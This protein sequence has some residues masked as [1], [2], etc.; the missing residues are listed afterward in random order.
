MPIGGGLEDE[1]RIVYDRFI[2]L[3]TRAAAPG[4]QVHVLV[5]TAASFDEPAAAKSK[6]ESLARYAPGVKVSVISRPTPQAETV[7]LIDA[8]SAIF[9]TGGD[10]KRITTRYRPD[11]ADSTP[12]RDAMLRLLTRG[13]VI[14]GTSAGD[15]MMGDVM[16]LTGRSAEALG[17]TTTRTKPGADDDADDKADPKPLGPQIGRGMGFLSAAMTDSHFLERHRFGRLVA[18]LEASGQ[19]LGVGVSENAAVEID[20]AT[21]EMVGLSEAESLLVDVGGLTRDG[22]TRRGIR[23]KL[24]TRG[25][26]FNL[27]TGTVPPAQ[28]PAG[29]EFMRMKDDDTGM[30]ARQFFMGAAAQP[31]HLTLDGYIQKAWKIGDGWVVVDIETAKPE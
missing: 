4:G 5:A 14:A 21:G 16:F 1:N 17:I 26:K 31:R 18:A 8:A 19:R 2:E 15:A 9:F 24:V 23:A 13:G 11:G 29:Q 27:L 20:L 10:Q 6:Q 22:L 3:A 12:E 28:D 7:A 30:V 25:M